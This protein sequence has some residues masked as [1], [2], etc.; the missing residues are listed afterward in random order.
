MTHALDAIVIVEQQEVE[1][2]RIERG[3]QRVGGGVDEQTHLAFPTRHPGGKRCRIGGRDVARRRRIEVEADM[4]APPSTA[5]TASGALTPQIFAVTAIAGISASGARHLVDDALGRRQRIV[6]A[7][8]RP[9]DDEIVGA[10]AHR[11]GRRYDAFLVVG[12]GPG[13]ADAGHH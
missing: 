9:P 10:A 6:G 4:L 11:F 13:R 7:Y 1:T 12:R 8:D 2:D 5:A 3:A